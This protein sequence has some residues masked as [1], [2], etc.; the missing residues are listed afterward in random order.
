MLISCQYIFLSTS[1]TR[2]KIK[3]QPKHPI[4]AI[5]SQPQET[6]KAREKS[7]PPLSPLVSGPGDSHNSTKTS[8][9]QTMSEPVPFQIVTR[10]ARRRTTRAAVGGQGQQVQQA[11]QAQQAQQ[12]LETKKAQRNRTADDPKPAR[13]QAPRKRRKTIKRKTADRSPGHSD[14]TIS[15][16]GDEDD[17]Y[18]YK[19]GEGPGSSYA[20]VPAPS[21]LRRRDKG[22][23]ALTGH[24]LEE[25]EEVFDANFPR[26]SR[27]NTGAL[28][29]SSPS[30]M[31]SALPVSHMG[32]IIYRE[33]DVEEGYCDLFHTN[34]FDRDHPIGHPLPRY[35]RADSQETVA[36]P[37]EYFQSSEAENNF[38]CDPRDPHSTV[39]LAK[40]FDYSVQAAKNRANLKAILSSHPQPKYNL[41][42]ELA[43]RNPVNFSQKDWDQYVKEHERY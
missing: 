12:S 18:L 24:D 26:R 10:A 13:A 3:S 22:S 23:N 9:P 40:E 36:L 14:S 2:G 38:P 42:E 43:D 28:D 37:E 27:V 15:L 30:P 34:N 5:L 6:S 16:D 7:P 35:E 32:Q 41:R 8:N 17:T 21:S 20:P 1:Q 4:M 39:N 19:F 11:Q 33:N 29:Q 25:G 31:K